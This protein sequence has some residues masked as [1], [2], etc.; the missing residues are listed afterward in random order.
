MLFPELNENQRGY[1]EDMGKVVGGD[2]STI[3]MLK[4]GGERGGE[5]GV[6]EEEGEKSAEEREKL[7][8]KSR[9]EIFAKRG[10][11]RQGQRLTREKKVQSRGSKKAFTRMCG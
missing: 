2:H 1:A 10:E 6:M 3:R 5:R 8:R 7:Q 9:K 4:R 11:R